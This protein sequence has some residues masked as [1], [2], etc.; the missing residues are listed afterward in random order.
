MLFFFLQ[1]CNHFPAIFY[2]HQP[3]ALAKMSLIA[4]NVPWSLWARLNVLLVY[5]YGSLLDLSY[6]TLLFTCLLPLKTLK[7]PEDKDLYWWAV[8]FLAYNRGIV[9]VSVFF[10]LKMVKYTKCKTF[11]FNHLVCNS[12]DLS[13]FTLLC[14]YHFYPSPELF[15]HPKLKPCTH[16][17]I[18]P[19]LPP[20]SS[21]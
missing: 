9:N 10:S 17:T 14:N 12:V 8:Q 5:V 7:V 4:G 3:W 16:Y 18:T 15:C 6:C 1:R 11:L 13:L 2:L 20:P 19:L 21:S